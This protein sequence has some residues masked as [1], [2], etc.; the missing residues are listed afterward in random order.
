MLTSGPSSEPGFVPFAP[1]VVVSSNPTSVSSSDSTVPPVSDVHVETPS[2][3][4]IQ[5]E[6]LIALEEEDRIMREDLER[7]MNAPGRA[8][9]GGVR[10]GRFHARSVNPYPHKMALGQWSSQ[11]ALESRKRQSVQQGGRRG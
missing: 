10:Q 2:P 3:L 1:V 8:R 5:E 9:P 11:H 7:R 6:E 4:T